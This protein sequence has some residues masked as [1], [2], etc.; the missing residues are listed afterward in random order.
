[1]HIAHS[2]VLFPDYEQSKA[3]KSR[4]SGF[5]LAHSERRFL[6][7][8]LTFSGRIRIYYQITIISSTHRLFNIQKQA[9]LH[10]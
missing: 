9:S 2:N 10:I 1:M 3:D 8:T 6:R 5:L 4:L 7:S